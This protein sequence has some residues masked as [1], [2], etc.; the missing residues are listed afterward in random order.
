MLTKNTD[1]CYTDYVNFNKNLIF[2]QNQNYVNQYHNKTAK[3]IDYKGIL[4]YN[5]IVDQRIKH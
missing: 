1:P 2:Y 3:N 4:W 5:N